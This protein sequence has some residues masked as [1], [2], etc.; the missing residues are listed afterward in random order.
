MRDRILLILKF[1]VIVVG[2]GVVVLIRES[3]PIISGYGAKVL[4]SGV[5]VAGRNPDQVLPNDLSGFPLSLGTYTLDR[6]DSSVTGKVWG[7]AVRKAVY[8]YGLGATLVSGMT[9]EEL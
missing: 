8:R 6:A 7:F 1:L 4:C 5:F 3:L 9:E 2:I